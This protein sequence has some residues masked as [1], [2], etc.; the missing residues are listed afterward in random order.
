MHGVR[1]ALLDAQAER[2]G[3]PLVK[4]EMPEMP[5]MENYE[6]E[7]RRTLMALQNQGATAAAYGDIFLEDLRIY[8]E[9]MLTELS[10]TPVF[11]LWKIPTR[12][13]ILEFVDLGF[14]TIVVCVNEKVLDKSFAGRIIDHEFL[15]DLPSDVDPCGENG[16]FHTF[17]FDGPIFTSPISVVT[18][19]IVHR[20]FEIQNA[21][22]ASGFWYCDLLMT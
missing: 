10:L 1:V 13:L 2:I 22:I 18:G 20:K 3:I 8:R 19:E 15:N 17:V 6:R 21:E 16:E 5:T 4:M 9:K 7:T 14:K 12:D 11:P